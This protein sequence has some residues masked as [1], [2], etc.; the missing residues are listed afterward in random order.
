MLR[1]RSASAPGSPQPPGSAEPPATDT[2]PTTAATRRDPPAGM[3]STRSPT[4]TAAAQ[5]STTRPRAVIGVIGGMGPAAANM[6]LEKTISLKT[7]ARSDQDHA[8]VFLDQAT[9]VPDRTAAIEAGSNAPVKPMVDSLK[10]LSAGGADIVAMTCNTAHHFHLELVEANRRYGLGVEL[11][12]IV[13]AT[14][15]ELFKQCPQARRVGLLATTGTV[16]QGIYQ[17]RAATQERA[18]ALEWVTP[19]DQVQARVMHGIYQGVKAGK[20][21]IGRTELLAA[22]RHLKERGVDAML[23]ACTEIPLVIR[24]GDIQRSDGSDIPMIDTLEALAKAAL[25]KA[26]SIE[27]PRAAMAGNRPVRV[28]PMLTTFTTKVDQFLRGTPARP[29]VI[30]D[31]GGMG[32]AAAA[33][34]S[35]YMV[36]YNTSARADQDHARLLLDQATDI[37]DRTAAIKRGSDEPAIEMG[38]SLRRLAKAGATDVVMTCNTAHHFFPQLEKVI[39]DEHLNVNLIHIVDATMDLL[40]QRR[41]GA[42]KVGLLATDGTLQQE[43]YQKRSAQQ[44]AEKGLAPLDWVVPDA[45]IQKKVMDGIYKGIKAGDAELGKRLLTEAARHMKDKG[46]DAMLLACTEIPIALEH[47]HIEDDKGQPIPMIDTLEAQARKCI[48]RAQEPIPATPGLLRQVG[49]LLSAC[50][51]NAHGA[52]SEPHAEPAIA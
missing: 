13:D 7:D 49:Q 6:F 3:P 46:V 8:R 41:P 10:R 45:D 9:D 30:G 48:A 21:E 4:R 14:L 24:T 15:T 40:D 16:G 1:P 5:T 17:N 52:D 42:K 25:E 2:L 51:S 33:M 39:R 11:L 50:H 12:H 26:E 18:K 29:R 23:L 35:R 20:P 47:V 37:P 32:P 31:I 44:R 27:H 36:T 38:N 43:I 28:L 22:A 34:F 19:D